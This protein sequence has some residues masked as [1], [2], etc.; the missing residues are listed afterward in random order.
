[1]A[2]SP[3]LWLPAPHLVLGPDRGL[4]PALLGAPQELHGSH[5]FLALVLG[6]Q[7]ARGLRH[8]AHEQQHEGGGRTAQHSQP[9][10]LED[11]AWVGRGGSDIRAG[12]SQPGPSLGVPA[13]SPTPGTQLKGW[14]PH[15]LCMATLRFVVDIVIIIAKCCGNDGGYISDYV[16]IKQRRSLCIDVVYGTICLK[17]RSR[18][19]NMH[20]PPTCRLS[21]RLPRSRQ[22][23]RLRRGRATESG[24]TFH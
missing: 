1:M 20:S 7:V 13:P 6:Q 4:F 21:G 22:G 8:A 23:W 16:A 24:E 2:P 5:G 17:G 14:G 18:R 19:I 15:Y 9:A 12:V 10:P 11:P 3:Q